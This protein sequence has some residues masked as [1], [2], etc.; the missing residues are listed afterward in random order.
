MQN[1]VTSFFAQQDEDQKKLYQ[2]EMDSASSEGGAVPISLPGRY[3]CEVTTFAYRQKV[4]NRM[5][6]FPEVFIS[7][8][9]KS[10]NLTINLKVVDGTARVPK[11]ATIFK[12]IVLCPNSKEKEEIAKVMRFTKPQLVA[13]LGTDK[14]TI[15]P[16]WIDENLQPKFEVNGNTFQLIKDHKM[17]QNIMALV[18]EAVGRDNKIRLTVKSITKAMP[19]DKSETFDRVNQVATEPQGDLSTGTP[20]E[21]V[22][23]LPYSEAVEGT[24]P[25]DPTEIEPF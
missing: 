20:D 2:G 10:L 25:A 22:T 15:T 4:N 12:N 5:R 23:D 24:V 11:G 16:E 17:K 13:L 3:L 21:S 7:E 1:D 18:D 19:G 6:V 9:K 14:I 8:N